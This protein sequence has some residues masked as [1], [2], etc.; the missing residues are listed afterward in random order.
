MMKPDDD[1]AL[2]RATRGVEM[3]VACRIRAEDGGWE[4]MLGQGVKIRG[5][6]RFTSLLLLRSS[7]PGPLLKQD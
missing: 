1:Y 3:V 2:I 5:C 7:Q 4:A 6:R